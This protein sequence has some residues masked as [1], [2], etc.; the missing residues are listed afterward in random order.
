MDE[1]RR[2]VESGSLKLDPEAGPTL[3]QSGGLRMEA[4][5]KLIREFDQ[6]LED[7]VGLYLDAGAAM[8]AYAAQLQKPHEVYSTESGK[9]VAE[10]DA[11]PFSYGKGDPSDPASLHLHAVTQGGLKARNAKDG[12]NHILLGQRFIVDVYTYWEDGYRSRIAEVLDVNRKTILADIFGDIRQIRISI[13]HH[14]GVA[15]EDV[16]K[17]KILNWFKKGDLIQLTSDQ[18]ETIVFEVRK[19]LVAFG[20]EKTGSSPGLAGR[21]GP[22]GH[23]HIGPE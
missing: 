22:S 11:L 7:L 12:R 4:V 19:W 17:C 3:L 14:R 15:L 16:E 8:I 20:I 23:R 21:W 13:I 9:S 6:T 2:R 1:R 10:L 18:F 5:L